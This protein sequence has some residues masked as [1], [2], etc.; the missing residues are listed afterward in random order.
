M[1]MTA[2][3]IICES[4]CDTTY[5]IKAKAIFDDE[6]VEGPSFSY[7]NFMTDSCPPVQPD[8]DPGT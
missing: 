1:N 7:G 3:V 4:K 5:D 2:T 8:D 6:T